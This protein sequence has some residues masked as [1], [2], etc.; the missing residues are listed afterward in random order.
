MRK[1]PAVMGVL[2]MVFGGGRSSMTAIGRQSAT[3]DLAPAV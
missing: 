2:A 3:N 1:T